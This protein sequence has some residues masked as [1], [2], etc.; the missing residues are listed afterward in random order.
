MALLVLPLALPTIENG[1]ARFSPPGPKLAAAT[2][3]VKGNVMKAWLLCVVC[4]LLL[5]SD[6][7]AA[8]IVREAFAGC[9][10]DWHWVPDNTTAHATLIDFFG[11]QLV[12]AWD[13]NACRIVSGNGALRYRI[14]AFSSWGHDY[15]NALL[16][17][18]V[19]SNE[20]LLYNPFPMRTIPG[21]VSNVEYEAT[22][23]V[24]SN[25]MASGSAADQPAFF[26]SSSLSCSCFAV[27]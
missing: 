25:R 10:A 16:Y 18:V 8:P 12:P 2:R 11:N 24:V 15:E 7:G 3:D 19:N 5:R 14:G 6:A 21:I 17:K 27:R 22:T 4:C 9:Q 1:Q 13:E 23:V 26:L 20:T